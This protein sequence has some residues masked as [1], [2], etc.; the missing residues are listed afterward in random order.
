[1]MYIED[2]TATEY[3]F[4]K[5]ATW[6]GAQADVLFDL[7]NPPLKDAE[8]TRKFFTIADVAD[9]TEKTKFQGN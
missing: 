7:A 2:T 6:G 5:L 9:F 1:M 3:K 8:F 4:C